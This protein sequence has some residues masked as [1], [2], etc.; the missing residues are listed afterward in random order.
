[1]CAVA[2]GLVLRMFATAQVCFTAFFGSEDYRCK[3]GSLVGSVAERLVLTSAAGAP[4]IGLAFFQ[5]NG[6]RTFL[7]NFG[8]HG[9]TV[10]GL[11]IRFGKE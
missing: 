8:F 10:R 9:I 3:A 5:V 11:M 6:K 2:I 1:M 7:S 4:M